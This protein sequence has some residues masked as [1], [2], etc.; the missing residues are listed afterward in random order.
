MPCYHPLS[1][2]RTAQG[3]VVFVERGD[4]IASLFLPCGQCVGCRRERSRQ[5]AI[6]C[7]NEASLY[8]DNC[9]ITLTYKDAPFSLNYRDFQLFLKRLRKRFPGR[10]IRFYMCGEYGEEFSRPHFHACLFNFNFPDRQPF[11]VLDSN[12]KLYRSDILDN[13]WPHGFSSIGEVT[14]ESA[15][16]VARYVMKKVNGDRAKDHYKVDPETG[17]VQCPEF[18][19]MSLKPGIGRKW[20]EKYTTDVYPHGLVVSRGR[21]VYPPKYYDK[22]YKT[23][24]PDSHEEMIFRRECEAALRFEES[25]DRRL[26]DREIVA[27]A[28]LALFNRD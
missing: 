26:A 13:L 27:K 4:I 19:H 3:E 28:R 1:A 20:I 17:E 21:E 22:Y 14:F 12:N 18:C 15:A 23:L 5:W 7:L 24:D 16:Y 2:Y 11:R 10:K 25:T 6:R 9:F 8:R